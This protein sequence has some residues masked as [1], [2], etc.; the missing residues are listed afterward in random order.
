MSIYMSQKRI[1]VVAPD[2]Y[3]DG[4][5]G[6]L[7][8]VEDLTGL[9]LSKVP[10]SDRR[11]FSTGCVGLFVVP[12]IPQTEKEAALV[13][14]QRGWKRESIHGKELDFCPACQVK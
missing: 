5:R 2:I 11:M 13:A 9:Q 14:Q 1:A 3:C 4:C 8:L 6:S 12:G 10:E 7:N